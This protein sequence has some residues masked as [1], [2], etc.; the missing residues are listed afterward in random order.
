MGSSLFAS[1]RVSTVVL[2]FS[3]H[4]HN[5]PCAETHP[6]R[7]YSFFLRPL[8]VGVIWSIFLWV[9]FGVVVGIGVISALTN[10]GKD[11][12]SLPVHVP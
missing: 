1:S 5:T 8:G 9:R 6:A 2:A 4:C 7:C 3:S 11:A 10:L 12:K